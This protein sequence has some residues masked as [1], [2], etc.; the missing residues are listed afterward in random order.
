MLKPESSETPKCF[1][2]WIGLKPMCY[3]PFVKPCSKSLPEM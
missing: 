3:V 2:R 1:K